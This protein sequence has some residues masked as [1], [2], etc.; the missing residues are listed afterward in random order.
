MERKLLA[1]SLV[2]AV[3]LVACGVVLLPTLVGTEKLP[4]W[5]GKWVADSK[6]ILGTDIE[7]GSRYVYSIDLDQVVEDRA[8]DIKRSVETQLQE[9]KIDGKV[10]I[11]PVVQGGF[12]VAITDAA[13]RDEVAKTVLADFAG[14]IAPR[15]CDA[16][17]A[18]SACF[19][20]SGDYAENI[21]RSALSTA[22][23]TVRQR[24]DKNGV[25]EPS[26]I[27]KGDDIIVELPDD[28]ERNERTKEQIKQAAKLEFKPVDA[29]G[30]FMRRVHAAVNPDANNDPQDPD[31]IALGV[32]A[33]Q[34][35]DSRQ[36]KTV[37]LYWLNANDRTETVT[38]DE[39]KRLAAC[40][41]QLARGEIVN[42]GVTCSLPG[43]DV[44]ALYLARLAKRDATLVPPSDREVA[45]EKEKDGSWRS[46][47]LEK[48]VRLTGASIEQA[49]PD[50][51][52]VGR[53]IVRLSFD[54]YGTRVFCELTENNVGG[55]FAT[56]LDGVVKSAPTVNEAIC[57]GQAQI[58]MAGR[59]PQ[60]ADAEAKNLANVLSAGSLPAPLRLESDTTVGPSI[61]RDAVDK[62]KLAFGLG[63]VLV[64]CIM[65]FI[66]RFSG[67][68]ATAAVAIN[69]LMMIAVMALFGATLTLPGIAAIVLTVG[70][71]VDG[72]VL[73]YERV[74]DELNLGKS[75]RGAVDLGFERALSAILDGQ[76]TTAAAGFVLLWFGSGPIKGFA[77]MLLIGI[78]TTLFTN[79]WVSRLFFDWYLSRRPSNATTLSI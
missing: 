7:G 48:A 69:V 72:N 70:M 68:I 37:N 44:I 59:T 62:A 35:Q 51:D 54:R 15:T 8:Y 39:G 42:G 63:V 10:N 46:Y 76:L 67:L 4:W 19:R 60:E 24:I 31:A 29:G 75:V 14:T 77:V 1:R 28:K 34:Y 25:A 65:L 20:V 78:G 52:E 56:V 9:N 66:Y 79:I 45:Y 30:D 26:V 22:V 6:V 17:E 57:G 3:I 23:E 36:G 21:R 47:L 58:T 49:A 74:R 33:L 53:A 50:Y 71:A 64:I 13:R 43:H 18:D 41:A 38:I 5:F 11:S 55:Q 12:A 27:E 2:L 32:R 16:T 73:I 61:G 40:D